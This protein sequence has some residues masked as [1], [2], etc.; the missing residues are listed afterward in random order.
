VGELGQ[1]SPFP[2]RNAGYRLKGLGAFCDSK[3]GILKFHGFGRDANQLIKPEDR[4]GG[5]ALATLVHAD[6]S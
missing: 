1:Q 5:G 2:E 4:W 6:A 3:P